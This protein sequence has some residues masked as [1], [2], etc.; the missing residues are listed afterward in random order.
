[1]QPEQRCGCYLT[2]CLGGKQFFLRCLLWHI[3]SLYYYEL[4]HALHILEKYLE[5]I[6]EERS[7]FECKFWT[8]TCHNLSLISRSHVKITLEEDPFVS[9]RVK[10]EWVK[11]EYSQC[12]ISFCTFSDDTLTRN[13]IG[14]APGL[15]VS[16]DIE[17][18]TR[19]A[20]DFYDTLVVVAEDW[21]VLKGSGSETDKWLLSW[22]ASQDI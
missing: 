2:F 17:F 8:C 11:L 1:M 19:K 20:D 3:F 5:Q 13:E 21:Q 10:P 4:K 14:V 15:S 9:K 7:S 12:Q 6:M 22:K 18:L 16:V